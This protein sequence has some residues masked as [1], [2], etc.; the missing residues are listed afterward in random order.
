MTHSVS[1]NSATSTNPKVGAIIQARMSSNRLPGK[2]LLDLTGLPVL[3]WVIRAAQSASEI[4]QIVVA[5]SSDSTDDAI[6]NYCESQGVTVYRGSLD[7]VLDRFIGALDAYPVDAVVRLT[8]DCPL[9]DPDVIDHVVARWRYE[10]ELDYV[11]T[12]NPRSLPR[13]LDVE[14]ASAGALHIADQVAYGTD[15]SHVTSALYRTPGQFLTDSLTFTPDSSDLRVTLDTEQDYL[16]LSQ[17]TESLG[18]RVIPHSELVT[19]LR[20]H[21]ELIALNADVQQKTLDES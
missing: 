17:V 7:D 3:A 11:S 19:F 21:P 2:S 9:L 1:A 10:P 12:V 15:R 13:G 14:V 18:N 8:G 5:T 16:L 6:A 20:R 4:D